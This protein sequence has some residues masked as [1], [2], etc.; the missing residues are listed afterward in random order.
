MKTEV[1]ANS[2]ANQVSLLA[3]PP[4]GPAQR[5]RRGGWGTLDTSLLRVCACV[6]GTLQ[7]VHLIRALWPVRHDHSLRGCA[8]VSGDALGTSRPRRIPSTV[9]HMGSLPRA[10]AQ[11]Q[12]KDGRAL[13]RHA[14]IPRPRYRRTRVDV[15]AWAA[16]AAEG[17]NCADA[18]SLLR[19][20]R[21][22]IRDGR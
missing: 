17:S 19:H 11:D 8:P 12:L 1:I 21:P 4:P 7:A 16:S 10:F 2:P 14:L 20:L 15:S 18:S 6:R 3:P 9:P 13:V 22:Y 5:S